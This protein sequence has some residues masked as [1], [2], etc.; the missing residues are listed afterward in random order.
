MKYQF[1]NTIARG[2]KLIT[3]WYVIIKRLPNSDCNDDS[4]LG[5]KH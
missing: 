3:I 5:G 2:N 4:P 1:M